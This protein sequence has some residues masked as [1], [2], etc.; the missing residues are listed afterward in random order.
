AGR[1]HG[2]RYPVAPRGAEVMIQRPVTRMLPIC[3]AAAL[4][5]LLAGGCSGGDVTVGGVWA[6]PA[7]Q[8][9]HTAIYMKIQNRSGVP[10]R[11]LS[12]STDVSAMVEIHQSAMEGGVMTMRPVQGGLAVE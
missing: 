12:V 8:G 1:R 4:L 5:L 9:Q 7:A 2:A 3:A 6:R 10:D 11:L